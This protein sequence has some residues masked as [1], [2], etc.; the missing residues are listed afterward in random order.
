M[1]RRMIAIA[2]AVLAG[3]ATLPAFAQTS[4]VT[5][6]IN[7][8]PAS[9]GSVLATLCGDP[10]APFPGACMTHSGM[11]D[12]KAGATTVTFEGVALGRYAIQA[13]HDE[14]GDMQ[15]NMPAEGY[16]FG[17]DASWPVTFESASIAVAGDTAAVITLQRIPGAASAPQPSRAAARGAPQWRRRAGRRRARAAAPGSPGAAA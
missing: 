3:A 15:M 13:F 6:T 7:D 11:A 2:C 16:A 5:L 17:N 8:I 4:T 1:T 12:A 10:K 14:N 9:K